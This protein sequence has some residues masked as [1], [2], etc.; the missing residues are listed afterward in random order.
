MPF[1]CCNKSAE[2]RHHI[3]NS[4]PTT[5][6]SMTSRSCMYASPCCTALNTTAAE[7]GASTV[8]LCLHVH[9]CHV[10][11]IR[12]KMDREAVGLQTCMSCFSNTNW[13]WLCCKGKKPLSCQSSVRAN[14]WLD[15]LL[16]P[17]GPPPPGAPTPP[18]PLRRL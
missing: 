15:G 5:Q 13:V 3:P 8:T 9:V 18:A 6:T 1:T 16:P 14:C 10:Q 7:T 4:V 11:H 12:I 17:W 2:T